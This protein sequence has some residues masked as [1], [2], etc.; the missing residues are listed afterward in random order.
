MGSTGR[1]VTIMEGEDVYR[2]VALCTCGVSLP[3]TR[4]LA[5]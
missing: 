4:M 3:I 5:A 2:G 1:G